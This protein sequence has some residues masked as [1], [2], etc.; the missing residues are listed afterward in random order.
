[1]AK[2]PI[3]IMRI[4]ARLNVGGPAIHVTLLTEHLSPPDYESLLVC[5]Q[6][7]PDEGDMT[8]L[9]AQRGIEPVYIAELGRALS[10]IR[11]LS[12]LYKLWRLMRQ[13]R[14]DVVHTHT[15]KAGFVGR[16]AAWLARVP[17]R[18]HTFH[19]HVFHG[20][21][22]P[23]KTKLFLWLERFTARLSDRLITISPGLRD[24]L[25]TEYRIAPVSK[26]EIVPLGLE[27]APY[28]ETPRHQ[29]DFRAEFN[30]P[31]DAP[32]IGIVGR[33]VP[34][35][36]HALF[37]QA[38]DQV[39]RT[40]PNAQFVIIGDGERRAEIEAHVDTLNLRDAVTF[41]GWL[42]DLKP[43][44]S[45]MDVLVISSDNEGT[46]VSII[47]ALAAGVAV[48]STAVGGV[49]DLLRNG[50]YGRLVPPH[51]PGALADAIIDA[52]TNATG[53]TL[54]GGATES[55]K[56]VQ[57]ATQQAVI[58]AYDISRLASDLAALYQKLLAAKS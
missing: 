51:D 32:L 37:L 49:P 38:A 16:I 42:Q 3:R 54:T 19:G 9:A 26:F 47:E 35:K 36:N 53:A 21:F 4:I 45:D 41:T 10:P 40:I 56:N 28:A 2:R 23:V 31:S 1:M 43:A 20:Y 46:P 48:V 17:V 55:D 22:S 24:E 6:I 13:F 58:A 44:Y 25:V 33:L 11:D 18:V 7:G 15:A 8:Y 14:P 30:I 52:A 57:T 12:T 5:G 27:L 39:R 50:D 29:G 34:I